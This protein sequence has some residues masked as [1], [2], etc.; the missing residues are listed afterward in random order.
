MS[1]HGSKIRHQLSFWALTAIWSSLVLIFAW[2]PAYPVF[3][4]S[5]VITVA[6][7]IS[8]ALTAPILGPAWG[9]LA[10]F[11]Y[12]FFSPYV[13][14]STSIGV[15]TFLRFNS[16]RSHERACPVQP[17][18][19]SGVDLSAQIAIWFLHPFAWYQAMPIVTWEYWLAMALIVVPPVRK[20][21]LSAFRSRNPASLPIALWCLA[22]IAQ[23][24]GEVATGNNIGV[25]V[26]GWGVPSMYMYWALLT[27]YYA[28]ADSLGCLAGALIGTAVLV[29]LKSAKMRILAI[30]LAE[31]KTEH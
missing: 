4:T 23:V 20:R 11:A 27:I 15:L 29:T 28:I 3:G 9:T 10:G 8:T 21:I 19:V 31:S 30:D 14:P 26:N 17:L 25:W 16:W 22:W 2:V 13:N 5:A 6:S 12:G 18:E 24:G 1:A 7:I